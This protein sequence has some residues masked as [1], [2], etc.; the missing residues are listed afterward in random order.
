VIGEGGGGLKDF[1]PSKPDQTVF[2]VSLAEKKSLWL[3]L[4]IKQEAAGHGSMHNSQTANSILFDAIKRMEEKKPI[5]IFDKTTKRMFR[6]LGKLNGGLKGFILKNINALWLRPFRRKILN[7]EPLLL[8][9]VTSS[10]QFTS[11]YNPSTAPNVVANEAAAYFDCRLLPGVKTKKF[12]RRLKRKL[13]ESKVEIEILDQSPTTKG[14]PHDENYDLVKSA[15]LKA[16]PQSEVLPV[17]FPA[18]TDNSYFRAKGV[19]C[20]G[21]LPLELS[22]ALIKSVHGTNERI[23]MPTVLKGIEAYKILIKELIK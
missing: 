8:N 22:P 14:S 7:S 10:V 16:Y 19:P 15:I 9:E 20:Y 17:L 18:T 6:Q 13:G 2:S 23:P 1:L 4:S 5:I 12:M 21:I 3:K 11:I